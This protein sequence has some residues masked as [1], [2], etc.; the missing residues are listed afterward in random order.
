MS[1]SIDLTGNIFGNL[2]V[3]RQSGKGKSNSILWICQ[4][5]CGEEQ[6]FSAKYLKDQFKSGA[7]Q[8]CRKCTLKK[9]SNTSTKH[10]KSDTDEFRIWNGIKSRC[11]QPSCRAYNKYGARGIKLCD[12]WDIG[13]GVQGGFECFLADMGLRPS[14]SH[15]IDRY[16][17]NAGNY[18]P[19][20]CRWATPQQQIENRRNTVYIT[21]RGE[22]VTL[23][24]GIRMAGNIVRRSNAMQRIQ[25]GWPIELALETPP[26]YEAERYKIPFIL[27]QGKSK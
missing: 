25:N 26:I 9:I 7:F 4:C 24:K 23:M 20:N 5:H 6:I 8:G 10:G 15:S 22:T 27:A 11:Q 1:R 17:N 16:P 12:R 2:T 21:Y 13:D 19:S 18:E 14:K 3:K